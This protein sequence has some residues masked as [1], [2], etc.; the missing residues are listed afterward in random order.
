MTVITDIIWEAYTPP[1]CYTYILESVAVTKPNKTT[2][3]QSD[4]STHP[5]ANH[6][7]SL[8]GQHHISRH[9]LPRKTRAPEIMIQITHLA[10]SDHT[11]QMRNRIHHV[12]VA[13]TTSWRLLSASLE[14]EA[15]DERSHATVA[16]GNITRRSNCWVHIQRSPQQPAQ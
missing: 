3:L 14:P 10:P 5:R 13:Q 4:N 11:V 1:D 15:P 16:G 8:Q 12:P 2:V 6:L 9:E 7:L